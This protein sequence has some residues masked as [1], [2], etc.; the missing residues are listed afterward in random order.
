MNVIS[1]RIGSYERSRRIQYL[2]E[3]IAYLENFPVLNL[4]LREKML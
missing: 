2:K 1:L 3:Q 4:L